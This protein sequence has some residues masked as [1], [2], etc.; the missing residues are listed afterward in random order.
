MKYAGFLFVFTTLRRASS[1]MS[2]ARRMYS[3]AL[4]ERKIKQARHM[5]RSGDTRKTNLHLD[6]SLRGA[7]KNPMFGGKHRKPMRKLETLLM[8][9]SCGDQ[10]RQLLMDPSSPWHELEALGLEGQA[11]AIKIQ[12]T[13]QLWELLCGL[14]DQ[15]I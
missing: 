4:P 10:D 2:T 6:M 9:L 5:W 14:M 11:S 12:P 8:L 15:M 13:E 3:A 1:E 7:L